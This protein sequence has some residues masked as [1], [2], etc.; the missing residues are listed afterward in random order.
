MEL[1]LGK[2]GGFGA[3]LGKVFDDLPPEHFRTTGGG[4]DESGRVGFTNS[5]DEDRGCFPDPRNPL[6]EAGVEGV[7]PDFEDVV[8]PA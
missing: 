1:A 7:E 5:G 4:P 8:G 3:G 6:L 2:E